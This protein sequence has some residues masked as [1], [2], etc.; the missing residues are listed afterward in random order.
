MAD[1]TITFARSARRELESLDASTVQRII[2]KID[3]LEGDPRPHG[4][5]KL[6]GE[7]DL[8]R[9]RVGDYRIIYA[10]SD[11]R[12]IV[13]IVRILHRKDVYR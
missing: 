8:W 6:E 11:A 7:K 9:V 12:R 10:V 1:Y 5:K 2:R 4:R 13:D 3:E